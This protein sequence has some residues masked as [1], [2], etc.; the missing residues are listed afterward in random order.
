MHLTTLRLQRFRNH[1]DSWFEF[2]DGT[3]ILLGDNGQGKTNVIEAVSYLCLTKSFFAGN[4]AL[5]TNFEHPMFEVEGTF[6]SNQGIEHRVR[7]A[8][9]KEREQKRYTHNRHA[10]DLLSSVIGM[11][12]IVICS[13]EHTP[14]TT[15][16]PGERRKF[17]DLVISQ[18]NPPYFQNLLE[19]RRVLKQRNRILLDSKIAKRD[20][21][22][23]LDPWDEQLAA[24]GSYLMV[25]RKQFVEEFQSFVES[26]YHHIVGNEEQPTI[27][28]GSSTRI[29][30]QATEQELRNTLLSELQEKRKEEARYGITLVGPHRDE[31]A[32]KINGLDLRKFASQGQHKTFLI[33][34][35]IGEFFYLN[36]RCR[37][38]PMMLLDDIF[39][40]L[41]DQRA[42]RLLQFVETLS[43]TF[44]TSTNV[45]MFEE[46]MLFGSRN[47]NFTIRNGT[48]VEQDP[49]VA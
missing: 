37:E 32:M 26:A 30:E 11:F 8:Y 12:P 40:E 35:K 4:D 22:K 45:H 36:E 48:V 9:D 18:S 41:D 2:G 46:R 10:V 42:S 17:V 3:N 43:Q 19:Y 13:P 21:S 47:K 31:F 27:T 5:V 15:E 49:V 23:Q 6:V 16:G 24:H 28:Y 39:S 25:R 20:C 34:M 38:T 44:I 29:R 33:A 14:I 1:L 7:I